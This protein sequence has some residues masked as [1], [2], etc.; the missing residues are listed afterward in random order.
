MSQ[1]IA[2]SPKQ[3]EVRNVLLIIAQLI[4]LHEA[5]ELCHLPYLFSSVGYIQEWLAY[6]LDDFM[7]RDEVDLM[8]EF[9]R[10]RCGRHLHLTLI[11]ITKCI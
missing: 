2:S 1:V 8:E 6:A 5:M 3:L 9:D 11:F 10:I 7:D 4:A